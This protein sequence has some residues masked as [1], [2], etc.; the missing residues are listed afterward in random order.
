[1]RELGEISDGLI[2]LAPPAEPPPGFDDRVVRT[3]TARRSVRGGGPVHRR[4][5]QAAAAVAVVGM[6][7][8]GAWFAGSQSG[9]QPS[10]PGL[11]AGGGRAL[12]AALM[13]GRRAV[14]RVV[15]TTGAEPWISMAVQGLSTGGMVRC[16]VG[17]AGGKIVTVGSFRITGGYGYWAA[18]LPNRSQVRSVRLAKGGGT[19]V[20]FADVP[21]V[22][23]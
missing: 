11:P 12:T 22:S 10:R 4:V 9:A 23:R 20:A 2:G 19:I 17:E 8:G 6:V 15:V 7:G 13:V 18:P 1:M 3:I 5:L 16:Q 14:G 21:R